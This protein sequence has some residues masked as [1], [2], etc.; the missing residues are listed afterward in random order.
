MYP[1]IMQLLLIV[2]S[3][4]LLSSFPSLWYQHILIVFEDTFLLDI[5]PP[6]NII[7]LEELK[8]PLPVIDGL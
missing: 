2:N 4:I 8:F 1:I 5:I 3:F 6:R 7:L